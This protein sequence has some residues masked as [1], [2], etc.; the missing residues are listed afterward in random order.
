[1]VT[2]IIPTGARS[3]DTLLDFV[4]DI[5]VDSGITEERIA[6]GPQP[7]L[8]FWELLTGEL[9]R[10]DGDGY[11]RWYVFSP[12]NSRP[13]V[14]RSTEVKWTE[15]RTIGIRAL[16]ALPKLADGISVYQ[17]S[18]TYIQTKTEN[19]LRHIGSL[20]TRRRLST[21]QPAY[22]WPSSVAARFW[23]GKSGEIWYYQSDIRF[24]IQMELQHTGRS[25]S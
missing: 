18:R 19:L 24:P 10:P 13:P 2:Q 25:S 12:E 3:L 4:V 15:T 5:M 21:T 11:E 1:M 22:Q 9:K 7:P 14:A 20:D 17:R 16:A 8:P 6:K 23:W